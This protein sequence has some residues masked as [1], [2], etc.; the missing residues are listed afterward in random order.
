MSGRHHVKVA[1]IIAAATIGDGVFAL[2]YVFKASGWLVGLFYLT[3]LSVIIIA[4]HVIYLET[5]EKNSEKKRLL[6]LAREHFGK[7][8]FWVGFFSIVVGLL[9]VLVA[10][11]VLGAGFVRLAAPPLPGF[12]ALVIFWAAVSLPVFL[13]DRRV[14]E[15]ELLGIACTS[16]VII[17]IFATAFPNVTFAG[18]PAVAPAADFFLPFGAILFALAGWTGVEPAYESRA[19][20][21]VVTMNPWK[22]VALGTIF[23]AALKIMFITGVL[24][25]APQITGDTVSGLL[26]WPIWKREVVAALGLFAVWTVFLPIS[27][28]VKNALERDLGWSPTVSRSTIVILPLL[29]VALGFNNFLLIVELVGGVFLSLQYLL[30]IAVGRKALAFSDARKRFFNFVSAVFIAGAVYE[31]WTFIVH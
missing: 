17:F 28:E 8:G 6:G 23:A 12:T 22:G 10:Y 7:R 13:S 14:V 20:A 30:I 25:S 11:L 5:L 4:A 18:A 19:K 27:R 31:L 26:G 24:G 1:A 2:P 29:L 15:L 3:V 21:G 16:A 9:L